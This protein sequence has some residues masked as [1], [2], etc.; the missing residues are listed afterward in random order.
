MTILRILAFPAG[1]LVVGL[2]LNSAMR[3][4]VLP[5]ATTEVIG[6]FVFRSY[7]RLFR[8][9]AGRRKSYGGRDR[10]MAMFAPTGL[11]SLPVAWV[12]VVLAGYMFLFWS[13]GVDGWR[14]TF[15][16]SG[17]SILT[18]GFT[19]VETLPQ[20]ALAFSE[21]IIGLGLIAL[22]ITYLPTMYA[23]F[24]KREAG[25]ALLEV[26]AGSPPSGVEMMMRF[27][28][29]DWFDHLPEMYSAW[30]EWFVDIEESH[31]S[32]PALVF[33]RSPVPEHSW[34]TAA[35]AMLD[36]AGIAVSCIDLPPDPQ[37]QVAIRAGYIAL[38]RIADFFGIGYD[39]DPRPD[40]PISITEAEFQEAYDRLAEAGVPMRHDRAQAWRDFAGWRVNYDTVLL[41]L[42]ALTLAPFAPWSSDR[43]PLEWHRTPRVRRWGGFRHKSEVV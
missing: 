13:V 42:C 9:I 37:G 1:I 11:L 14:T 38:R 16:V 22:L 4:V 39:P 25:V 35:G 36:G 15:S 40:D 32:L 29:I 31:T 34:V 3:L 5:R 8:G 27:H 12:T 30:E 41:A 23:A 24:R 21:A 10:T 43:S 28:Q 17:S 33:F 2:A 20:T 18:L 6:R 26:R 19:P 7:Y